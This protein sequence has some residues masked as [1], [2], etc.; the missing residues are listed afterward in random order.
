M[1]PLTPVPRTGTAPTWKELS[2]GYGSLA[3]S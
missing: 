2:S 3:D 1:V